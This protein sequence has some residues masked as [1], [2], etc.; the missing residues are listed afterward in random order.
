MANIQTSTRTQT[1]ATPKLNIF[2]PEKINH[3]PRGDER[4]KIKHIYINL[5]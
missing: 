1:Y 2:S 5:I 4:C 3:K